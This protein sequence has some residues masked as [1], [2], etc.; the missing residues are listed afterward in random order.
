MQR[1]VV[2]LAI[3]ATEDVDLRAGVGT[4]VGERAYEYMNENARGRPRQAPRPLDTRASRD[5]AHPNDPPPP[6]S[7][8]STL[9][10][11]PTSVAVWFFSVGTSDLGTGFTQR[12]II[13]SG[14]R[15]RSSA[16]CCCSI[17]LCVG[18]WEEA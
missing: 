13:R 8:A 12:S 2:P 10:L 15:G 9:T 17:D 3:V 14:P 16:S 6:S 5:I 11:S 1:V 18:V 4:R 7:F